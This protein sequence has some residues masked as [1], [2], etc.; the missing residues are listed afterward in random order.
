MSQ[1]YRL[2][3]R[4]NNPMLIM[5][6]ESN[7]LMGAI[8]IAIGG[9]LIG[10]KLIGLIGAVVYWILYNKTQRD[11]GLRGGFIHA[12]WGNGLWVDGKKHQFDAVNSDYYD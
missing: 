12:L 1:E 11:G 7:K 5:S 3:F 10:M 9:V 6:I 8:I 2:P 4:Q